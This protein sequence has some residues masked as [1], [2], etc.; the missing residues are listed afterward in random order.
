MI[1]WQ[2]CF[3]GPFIVLTSLFAFMRAFL[4]M[5]ISEN[6]SEVSQIERE[7][8]DGQA[9]FFKRCGY[10]LFQVFVS[11]VTPHMWVLSFM[12]GGVIFGVIKIFS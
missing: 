6:L 8:R 7:I 5:G 11:I 1:T 12:I 2:L 4:G 3:G 9:G 10:F